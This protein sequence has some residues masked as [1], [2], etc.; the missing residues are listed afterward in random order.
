M[1]AKVWG[2]QSTIAGSWDRDA[3]VVDEAGR[4][5]A[6]LVAGR[7]QQRNRLFYDT[8]IHVDVSLQEHT[9]ARWRRRALFTGRPAA[10]RDRATSAQQQMSFRQL[11]AMYLSREMSQVCSFVRRLKLLTVVHVCRFPT[12]ASTADVTRQWAIW[13]TQRRVQIWTAGCW[14]FVHL[15]S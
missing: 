14:V 1:C 8:W 7:F 3:G 4:S 2:V 6:R 13:K 10:T 9:H 5:L 11:A 12:T 15:F